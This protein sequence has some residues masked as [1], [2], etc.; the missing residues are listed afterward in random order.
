M[1]ELPTYEEQSY[2]YL[3]Y[4]LLMNHAEMTKAHQEEG[5][6]RYLP[7]G[8]PGRLPPR[9]F[10]MQRGDDEKNEHGA[11]VKRLK[12]THEYGSS[13]RYLIYI[14]FYATNITYDS[15]KT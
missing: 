12:T 14:L 7:P 9:P 2:E 6:P 5:E 3:V 10:R 8:T 15:F 4:E 1:A 13:S 11:R